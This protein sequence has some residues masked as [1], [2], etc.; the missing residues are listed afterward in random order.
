MGPAPSGTVSVIL[1]GKQTQYGKGGKKMIALLDLW[2]PIVLSAVFVFIASSVIHM[3]IQ[4][5]KK[6]YSR[7]EKEDSLLDTLRADGIP[8][9]EYMFP[10][11]DSMKDAGTP[12][13]LE[14][15]KRGPVGFLLVMPSGGFNMGK[16]LLNWFLYSIL[17]GAM[18]A[19]LC[20]IGL[21]AGAEYMVVFR[22]AGTASML[23][24]AVGNIPNSIWKGV[25]WGVTSKFILDGIVYGLVTAGTFAW[26]WPDAA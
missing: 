1:A 12:E 26:L 6:D 22:F 19:Y 14:K 25:R 20:T 9:G 4:V 15:F 3:V 18:V 16:N 10:G 11:C 7:L 24:Y 8:P 2:L 23:A 21:M 13:M 5:H 17:I